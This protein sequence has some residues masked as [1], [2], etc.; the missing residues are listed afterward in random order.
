MSLSLDELIK[1][2]AQSE[3]PSIQNVITRIMEVTRDP[4]SNAMDLKRVIEVDPP[5]TARVLKVANSALYGMNRRMSE[6]LEAII[7]IGFEA[8]KELAMSQKVGEIFHKDVHMDGYSRPS[9]WMH[10]VSV[11]LCG[12]MIYRREFRERG[13]E[14]YTAGLLHDMGII[15]EEQFLPVEFK[16]IMQGRRKEKKDLLAME[17]DVLGYCHED[18]VGRLAHQ[19]HFPESLANALATAERPAVT[20]PEDQRLV[21]TLTLANYACRKARLGFNERV[22]DEKEAFLDLLNR[23]GIKEKSLSLIMVDVEKSIRQ[24]QAEGWF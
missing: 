12:K 22:R 8:V 17:Q 4:K 6:I 7:C 13:D 24:M 10:S 20:P 15:I 19:W 5:L 21:S 1:Q 23:L 2:S 14:V 3:L 9:L 11:A 16:R 18:I